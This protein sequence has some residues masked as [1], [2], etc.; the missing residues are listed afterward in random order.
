MTSAYTLFI[1]LLVM[2]DKIRIK[3]LR[4]LPLVNLPLK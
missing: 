3:L 4:I 2:T 1:L